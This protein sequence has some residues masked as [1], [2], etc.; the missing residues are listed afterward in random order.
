MKL[1]VLA[2]GRGSNLRA[3]AEAIDAGQ[4]R[5]SLGAVI[6]DRAGAPALRFAE[7]RGVPTEHVPLEKGADRR[8]WDERLTDRVAHH[9]PDLVVLAGFMRIVRAPLLSRYQGRILNV[10]PALLPSFPG[11]DA[12]A[13]A[14]AAGV[15]ISGCTVHVVD[16]GVDQGPIVAQAAVPVLPTD[17]AE[18]LHQR[19]QQQEHRLLARVVDW[20]ARGLVVLE[21]PAPRI[22]APV[23]SDDTHLV[24]PRFE[25]GPS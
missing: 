4:C 5:A 2:S 16:E 6:S 12:P 7:D 1:V 20:V 22:T 10:H 19:I 13:Q 21:G 17:D 8:R 23:R 3:L 14:I 9:E 15:R 18:S 25:D 11:I 24:F